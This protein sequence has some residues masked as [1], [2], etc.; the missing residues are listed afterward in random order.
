[1]LFIIFQASESILIQ[2]IDTG[3][4]SHIQNDCKNMYKLPKGI[5]SI[6]SCAFLCKILEVCNIANTNFQLP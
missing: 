5:K 3:E 4:Y 6:K 2:L 1:M